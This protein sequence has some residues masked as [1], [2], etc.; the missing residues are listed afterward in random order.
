M[1][2]KRGLGAKRGLDTLLTGTKVGRQVVDVIDDAKAVMIKDVDTD[3][4]IA[5]DQTSSD[6]QST[7]QTDAITDAGTAPS[8]VAKPAPAAD[9]D[10][11][12]DPTHAAA[13]AD[14]VEWVDDLA[15][16]TD[17]DSIKS[18]QADALH[19]D[20]SS[21]DAADADASTDGWSALPEHEQREILLFWRHGLSMSDEA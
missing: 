20:V 9:A 7:D 6:Q 15:S 4:P 19:V 13:D 11:V 12:D 10:L 17:A 8:V 14:D 3:S 1:S 16:A 5:H 21:T 18:V 2:K